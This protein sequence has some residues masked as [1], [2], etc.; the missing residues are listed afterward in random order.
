M[1][2][3]WRITARIGVIQRG[4]KSHAKAAK[5]V[6]NNTLSSDLEQAYTHGQ[7]A[8]SLAPC[9]VI[10]GNSL[11]SKQRR[12]GQHLLYVP[13]HGDWS[14]YL[15]RSGPEGGK[16]AVEIPAAWSMPADVPYSTSIYNHAFKAA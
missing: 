13:S 9:I 15:A 11:C 12:L 1:L 6:R 4:G 8:L 5:D 3:R 14:K 10:A 7:L 2:Q 16:S